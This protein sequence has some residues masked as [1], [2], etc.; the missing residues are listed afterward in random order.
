MATVLTRTG[1]S[2]VSLAGRAAISKQASIEEIL[3]RIR[4]S[5][6]ST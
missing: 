3:E 2:Y 4:A 5:L 1:D 6:D